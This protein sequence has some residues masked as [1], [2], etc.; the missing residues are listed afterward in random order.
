[1]TGALGNG[2]SILLFQGRPAGPDQSVC[3]GGRSPVYS[4]ARAT[5]IVWCPRYEQVDG[6]TSDRPQGYSARHRSHLRHGAAVTLLACPALGQDFNHVAPSQP[7]PQPPGTVTA[8][9]PPP[10]VP[11]AENKL[12][13]ADLKGLR[14]VDSVG[15]IVRNGVR[16]TGIDGRSRSAAAR[17]SRSRRKLAAFLGK[18][19]YA[20]DLPQISQTMLDWYRAH[21]S[22]GRRCRLS[23][24]GHHERHGA[25]RGHR[26]QAGPGQ[27]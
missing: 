8:P 10:I 25:G 15:K 11:P 7:K 19:L 22:A 5:T 6:E 13:L 20:N 4:N 14:F 1:M 2:D 26:L 9:A 24:A 12:L 27:G 23:R 18:P 16:V 21:Q 17:Q 3:T